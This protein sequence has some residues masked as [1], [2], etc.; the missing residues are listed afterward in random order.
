MK[1]LITYFKKWECL[2]HSASSEMTVHSIFSLFRSLESPNPFCNNLS[3]EALLK[4]LVKTHQTKC[5]IFL[6]FQ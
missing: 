3:V 5:F 4:C 2:L 6:L 1:A